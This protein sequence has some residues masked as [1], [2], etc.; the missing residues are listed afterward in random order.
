MM[1]MTMMFV[2]TT[3]MKSILLLFFLCEL[4]FP[5]FAPGSWHEAFYCKMRSR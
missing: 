2:M 1:M 4:E 5:I 3:T